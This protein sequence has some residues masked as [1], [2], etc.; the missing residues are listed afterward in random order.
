M[1][2][3]ITFNDLK[4]EQ[5]IKIKMIKIN[6]K[7]IEIKQY[8]SIN[9]KLNLISRVLE[10]TVAGNQYPFANPVQIDVFTTLEIIY[11]YAGI[12]FSE[13]QKE[14]PAQ[15]Y[16]ELEEQDLINIIISAIPQTEYEFLLEG[17]DKTIKSYYKYRN[18]AKGIIEDITADYSNLDLDATEI[19][20]KIGD[21]NNMALLKDVLQKLG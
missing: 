18:S 13:E 6:D 19:Q 15:L 7:E 8:L 3:K 17:I 5:P 4:K 2:E 11:A 21:P 14:N 16:D 20:K 1:K 12:A 10:L 9:D